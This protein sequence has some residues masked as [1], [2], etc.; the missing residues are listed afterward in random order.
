MKVLSVASEIFPLIK[1]GGLAD[2][3][4]ALPA[5]LADEG[6]EVRSLLPGYAAVLDKA[7][8]LQEVH[9]FRSLFG[10]PARVFAGRVDGLA[11]Y[12][13]EAP[14]LY[15]R[16]GN[17]YV[18]PQGRDWPDN[19]QRFAALGRVA[20]EIGRGALGGFVSDVVHAHDW[21][22]G[23]APA[24]LHYSDGPR[25][26]TVMTVHNLAFQGR[27]PAE[28][29]GELG[30]P[31]RAFA[32]D[33]V[34]YFGGIGFLKGGLQL[35]DRITTVSPTYAAEICTPEAGMGLDGLLRARSAVLSGILN[36]IDEAVWNPET[37]MHLTA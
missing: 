20:A 19:A 28:F 31:P 9:S 5:A 36:G 24:Y 15:G 7:G 1:T 25:P 35:A 26:G 29:L 32:L 30:L 14:H 13:I 21:Q 11:I 10:G 18:G 2:V 4:G 8:L 34:E 6:V 23:L 22:A 17:P 16:P 12:A 33:G 27:F 3:A 37:D